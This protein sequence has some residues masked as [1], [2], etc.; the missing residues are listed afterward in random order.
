MSDPATPILNDS[1]GPGAVA[2]GLR[3][4]RLREIIFVFLFAVLAPVS[5][6]SPN[7]V[8]P[9]LLLAAL[10]V[11]ASTPLREVWRALPKPLAMAMGMLVAFGL[12]TTTWSIVPQN[13]IHKALQLVA[14][15][16]AILLLI[17]WARLLTAPS[18]HR[19]GRW[20]SIGLVAGVGLVVVEAAAGGIV[21]HVLDDQP[22]HAMDALGRY[23]RGL[24]VLALVAGPAVYW[25]GGRFGW[26]AAGL[27][28]V[29]VAVAAF[30]V[31][32][33]AGMAAIL[34]GVIVSVFVV[35]FPAA[36]PRGL[37]LVLALLVLLAPMARLGP[38]QLP[39]ETLEEIRANAMYRISSAA[40]RLLI[41]Q[42]VGEKIAERPLLGWGLDSSRAIPGGQG[43]VQG[44][45][46]LLPLHP[47]N[48][49][50]QL[51]LELGLLGGVLGAAIAVSVGLGA[52]R[53]IGAGSARAIAAG[54][55]VSASVVALLGFGIWQSWWISTLGLV[56]ACAVAVLPPRDEAR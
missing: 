51:W 46:P 14:L 7:A 2:G 45:S 27:M 35:R 15:F 37:A 1:V 19:V 52:G 5:L 21:H 50:L 30:L 12:L 38:A 29:G 41:W 20:L 54:M 26:L 34:V 16:A 31:H 25:L 8:V 44:F 11:L 23:K 39:A 48:A 42:F 32:S 40:H 33:G 53:R 36:G 13:S 28:V 47:H 17:A 10:G 18:R 24:V 6:L 4:N 56:A 9:L 43:A 49:A 55:T 22:L 3:G